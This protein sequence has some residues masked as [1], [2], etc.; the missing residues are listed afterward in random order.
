ME[1]HGTGISP[2]RERQWREMAELDGA[3]MVK[4]VSVD[5]GNLDTDQKALGCLSPSKMGEEGKASVKFNQ[6]Y[7]SGYSVY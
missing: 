5:G 3:V 2:A 1:E 7:V 6:D 4:A